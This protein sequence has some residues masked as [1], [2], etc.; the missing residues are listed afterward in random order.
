M[1]NLGNIG[2]IE[3][4]PTPGLQGSAILQ[5]QATCLCFKEARLAIEKIHAKI[6]SLEGL[7][8]GITGPSGPPGPAGPSGA[9]GSNP[10]VLP[11]FRSLP[12]P[13]VVSSGIVF[14]PDGVTLLGPTPYRVT[15]CEIHCD[16]EGP[17]AT[18]ATT[19]TVQNAASSPTSTGGV[20][21]A[22]GGRRGAASI[23][24]AISSGQR[25]YIKAPASLNGVQ[26]LWLINL[27]LEKF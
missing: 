8:Q 17:A 23:N 7:I 12:Y 4:R 19:F 27:G 6:D 21:I 3:K 13:F 20:T 11:A 16:P 26:N 2:G 15:F 24:V 18:G 10:N 14:P 5:D 9:D 22:S 25:L 1:G